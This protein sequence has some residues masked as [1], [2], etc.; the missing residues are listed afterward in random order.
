LNGIPHEK[1]QRGETSVE[2]NSG[3]MAGGAAHR[4]NPGHVPVRCTFRA[5]PAILLQTLRRAA[6]F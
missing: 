1:P 4:N 5:T 3:E 2:T 6:A